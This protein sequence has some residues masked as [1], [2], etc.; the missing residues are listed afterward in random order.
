MAA[1]IIGIKPTPQQFESLHAHFGFL[2][3]HGAIYLKGAHIS[4]A[5]EGKVGIV[6][7]IFEVGLH[8]PTINFFNV[9]M[10]QYGFFVDNLSPN[11]VNKI[12]GFEMAC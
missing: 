8:L 3:E 4:W 5:L 7:P 6:I 11:T 9:I 2:P 12:V 1:P 10:R